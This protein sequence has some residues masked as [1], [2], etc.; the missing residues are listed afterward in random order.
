MGRQRILALCHGPGTLGSV[1][2]GADV[3]PGLSDL[4]PP[5]PDSA[6]LILTL[7]HETPEGPPVTRLPPPSVLAW[8]G[9]TADP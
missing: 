4:F 9:R 7:C 6:P 1:A 5:F 2:R 8:P 3:P